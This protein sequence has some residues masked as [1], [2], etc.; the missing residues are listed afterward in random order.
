MDFMMCV[1]SPKVQIAL[2][3]ARARLLNSWPPCAIWSS[4]SFIA[5][6]PLR[7]LLLDA[8]SPLILVKR[9]LSSSKGGPPSN[10]SQTLLPDP[11]V[12][13]AAGKAVLRLSDLQQLTQFLKEKHRQED[14]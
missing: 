7:L 4:P 3:C 13:V 9:S 6:A 8:T 11:F 10:N 1:M 14:H 2:A 12:V 5:T